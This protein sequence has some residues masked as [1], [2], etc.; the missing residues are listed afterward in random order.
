M[1]IPIEQ[2]SAD[3]VQGLVEEFITREGTDYGEVELSL[4]EKVEQVKLQLAQG[5]I[6]IVFDAVLESVSLKDRAQAQALERDMLRAGSDPET[7]Q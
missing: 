3:A 1:I 4:Q 5:D 7:D 6:V 2:L